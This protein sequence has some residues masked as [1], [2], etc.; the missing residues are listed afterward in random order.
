MSRGTTR[1]FSN[2][3]TLG[4]TPNLKLGVANENVNKAAS[5]WSSS[6]ARMPTKENVTDED[7]KTKKQGSVQVT[8]KENAKESFKRRCTSITLTVGVEVDGVVLVDF[9]LHCRLRFER[10]VHV[11]WAFILINDVHKD[12]LVVLL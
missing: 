5:P 8:Q 12:K 6:L 10:L 1:I 2:G 7:I 3:K 9:N 11:G 4:A